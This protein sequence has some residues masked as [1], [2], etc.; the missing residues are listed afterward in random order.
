MECP[1]QVNQVL[2][3]LEHAGFEAWYV[4][5]CVRDTVLGRIPQD[6]DVTTNAHP[7]QVLAVFGDMALPTGIQHGTVTVKTGKWHVEVTTY[8]TDGTYINHRRPEQVTFVPTIEEDLARRDFTINAMAV[9]L[10]GEFR[11]PFGGREDLHHQI[12]RCV[13]NPT[14]RFEEDALRILRGLRF[15]SQ[16]G[17]SIEPETEAA[18]HQQAPL[19]THIAVERIWTE[20]ERLLC[21]KNCTQI[22]RNHLDVFGVFWPELLPM[23]GFSQQNPHHCYDLW[24]HTLHTVE[25]I[26]AT[27]L[28]RLSAL[29]HDIGKFKTFTLDDQG[30]GH[31]YRHQAVG[32]PIAD[33]MLQRLKVPTSLREQVVRLVEWHDRAIPATPKAVKRGMMKLGAPLFADLLRLK[34]ADNLAQHPA[35]HGRQQELSCLE[36]I[37]EDVLVQGQCF[38]LK[39]LAVNGHDLTAMGFHGPAIGQMLQQL[40]DGVIDGIFAN[41]KELLLSVAT[42]TQNQSSF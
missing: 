34:R 4:G 36:A 42:A 23:E 39:Q 8:R 15:A 19:L 3:T 25:A 35:Y 5:G 7:E 24:E 21:G 30:V 20:T 22:L 31:F 29:L 10:A 26:D 13:G 32:M 28:L 9:N 40:L 17:C 6:W 1:K 33:A 37:L 18:I 41:E 2:T 27:I 16:L 14:A 38:S 11:D 12:I